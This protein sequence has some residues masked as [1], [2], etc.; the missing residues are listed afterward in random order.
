VV[1][2]RLPRRTGKG[3]LDPVTTV[4]LGLVCPWL[5]RE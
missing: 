2:R 1:R 3:F 5:S 4:L